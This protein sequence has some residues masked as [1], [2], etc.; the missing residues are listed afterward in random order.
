MLGV[1]VIFFFVRLSLTTACGALLLFP[2]H[3]E[4]FF[5]LTWKS[6][7]LECLFCCFTSSFGTS[8]IFSSQAL[9]G[10]SLNVTARAV[11]VYASCQAT[12]RPAGLGAP[13]LSV[14]SMNRT[15]LNEHLFVCFFLNRNW[16]DRKTHAA[17]AVFTRRR[18]VREFWRPAFFFVSFAL[19][20]L[21]A[22]HQASLLM[23][24]HTCF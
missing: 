14:I 1:I 6:H 23:L 17:N 7:T 8:A 10:S 4:G 3:I 13:A 2:P 18:L 9:R 12:R 5:F 24:M 11:W 21:F 16:A 15:N 22:N 19:L 20:V